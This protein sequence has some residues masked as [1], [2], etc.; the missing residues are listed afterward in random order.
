[1]VK[2]K[3]R[4]E[5]PR[6]QPRTD[7]QRLREDHEREREKK[8]P[9]NKTPTKA[10]QKLPSRAPNVQGRPPPN[11]QGRPGNPVSRQ[12]PMQAGPGPRAPPV[13]PVRAGPVSSAK[14]DSVKTQKMALEKQMSAE[15]RPVVDSRQ[16][17]SAVTPSKTKDPLKISGQKPSIKLTLLNKVK[18]VNLNQIRIICTCQISVCFICNYYIRLI[19]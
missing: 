16:T 17:K 9:P 4:K 10:G 19:L 11:V 8:L 14:P 5:E 15:S 3:A 7:K 12:P 6:R 2:D 1:M 13:G 18:F